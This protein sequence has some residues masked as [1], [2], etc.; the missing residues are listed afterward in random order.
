MI[1]N[2]ERTGLR[3]GA[4]R[5]A[6]LLVPFVGALAAIAAF[7]ALACGPSAPTTTDQGATTTIM[8]TDAAASAT[9][10][11][12]GADSETLDSTGTTASTSDDSTSS[13]VTDTSA[14]D[15]SATDTSDTSD[16]IPDGPCAPN[17]YSHCTHPVDCENDAW[18]CGDTSVFDAN[19]CMRTPCRGDR[20]CGDDEACTTFTV[21]FGWGC[22]DTFTGECEC[23]NDPQGEPT[24]EIRLC[25]PA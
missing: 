5:S 11:A 3:R 2:A 20:D 6:Q 17:Q 9:T 18:D 25:A 12:T 22:F 4:A 8:T 15:T 23:G 10:A 21:P 1:A 19:G 7:G 24:M 14:T 13:S 16:S